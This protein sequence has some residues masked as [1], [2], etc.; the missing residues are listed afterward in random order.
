MRNSVCRKGWACSQL[1]VLIHT[2]P[3]L[4]LTGKEVC[5]QTQH[6]KKASQGLVLLECAWEISSLVN[7][8][9]LSTEVCYWPPQQCNVRNYLLG[10]MQRDLCTTLPL[11]LRIGLRGH[12]IHFSRKEF[13]NWKSCVSS[14]WHKV[15]TQLCLWTT[16]A[17]PAHRA[18]L[19]EQQKCRLMG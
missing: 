11:I 13:M 14:L 15:S 2:M 8:A 3:D 12:F 4:N 1:V 10:P 17:F 7:C 18:K 5:L 9:F 19:E 16:S 6:E